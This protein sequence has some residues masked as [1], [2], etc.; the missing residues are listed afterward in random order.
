MACA[1]NASKLNLTRVNEIVCFRLDG[2]ENTL[3]VAPNMTDLNASGGGSDDYS[4]LPKG[5]LDVTGEYFLWTANAGTGRLDAYLVR[6][7]YGQLGVSTPSNESPAAPAPAP[8]PAAP[9][10]SEPAPVVEPP[11]APP[12]PAPAP[13]PSPAPSVSSPAGAVRWMGLINLAASGGGLQ[14]T[15]GC[16]GCPDASAVS[17]QQVSG[18][19]ALNFVADSGAL[20][21]IGLGQG[22]IGAQAGD[23]NF[24]LRLQGTTVEVR[25]MGSYKTETSFSSGDSFRIAIEGGVVTCSKNGSVFYRSTVSAGGPLRVH[26]VLFDLGATL[27]NITL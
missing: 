22:S 25:E 1:S 4:K 27:R 14:K 13:L 18:N 10:P 2:S 23:I 8:A 3:V 21:I 26:A 15:G 7:P 5:N 16:D 17:E 11:V 12:T 24:A 6:I 20:R 9:P 19:G